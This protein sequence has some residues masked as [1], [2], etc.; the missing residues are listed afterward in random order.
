MGDDPER[1]GGGWQC[2]LLGSAMET[3][4][5]QADAKDGLDEGLQTK[6]GD[7]V[8]LL[9]R[10]VRFGRLL[11][12][13][14]DNL[15]LLLRPLILEVHAH[16]N[17]LQ[18]ARELLWAHGSIEVSVQEHHRSVELVEVTGEA[19]FQTCLLQLPGTQVA[20]PC[21]VELRVKVLHSPVVGLEV[22][23]QWNKEASRNL[24]QVR[25]LCLVLDEEVAA[26]RL[27]GFPLLHGLHDNVQLH[28]VQGPVSISV[29]QLEELFDFLD[30]RW[31]RGDGGAEAAREGH[32]VDA[33]HQLLGIDGTVTAL[34][35]LAEKVFRA[36]LPAAHII[37]KRRE[38]CQASLL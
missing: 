35:E 22:V 20:M 29:N 7:L 27:L 21:S 14:V 26:L 8:V 11:G 28:V 32:E 1:L 37:R 5:A 17:E 34:V 16:L 30:V 38:D 18:R 25:H 36:H 24:L 9:L 23:P 10:F 4:M 13:G 2:G 3:E 12:E 6:T 33:F 15:L 19:K 31:G